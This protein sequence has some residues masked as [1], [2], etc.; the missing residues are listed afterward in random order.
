MVWDPIG[1]AEIRVLLE[2]NDSPIRSLVFSPDGRTLGVARTIFRAK[3]LLLLDAETGAVR[4]GLPVHPS[5]I[6]DLAFSP[7]GR[8][9]ATAG[10]DRSLRLWDLAAGKPLA[11][12]PEHCWVESVAFSP[13]GRWLAYG[14]SDE[15]V[16]LLERGSTAEESGGRGEQ[17]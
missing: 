4:A 10:L 3:R 1:G 16:R 11:S 12:A 17:T 14:G 6:N 7:D 13:D 15:R 9:L 8:T 2:T 5:G